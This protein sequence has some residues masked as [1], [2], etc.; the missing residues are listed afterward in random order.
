M[1]LRIQMIP[2]GENRGIHYDVGIDNP[3]K[4]RKSKKTAR[5]DGKKYIDC[6]LNEFDNEIRLFSEMIMSDG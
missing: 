5:Q 2:Y 1:E 4:L 3:K 6:Q